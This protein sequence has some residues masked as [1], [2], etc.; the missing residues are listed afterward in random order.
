M[1]IYYTKILILKGGWENHD[2]FAIT[3]MCILSKRLMLQLEGKFL[4]FK[5]YALFLLKVGNAMVFRNS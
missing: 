4:I 5:T 3:F 1:T 2:K